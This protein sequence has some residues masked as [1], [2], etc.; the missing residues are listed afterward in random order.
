MRRYARIATSMSLVATVLVV[1]EIAVR[2]FGDI[3][4]ADYRTAGIWRRDED[5]GW[6][7][8][9]DLDVVVATGRGHVRVRTDGQGHRIDPDESR[10]HDGAFRVAVIGDSFVEALQ[11]EHRDALT[12]QLRRDL[13]H[14][15]RQPVV[16][17][18]AGVSGWGPVQ[19]GREARRLISRGRYDVVVVALLMEN[20]V[21]AS[22]E[23]PPLTEVVLNDR[24]YWPAE[25]SPRSVASAVLQPVSD[26]F[27][28]R[29]HLFHLLR[30][31]VHPW[32]ARL[33]LSTVSISPAYLR[34][35]EASRRWS[36]TADLARD[37]DARVRQAG[38]RAIFLL[39]PSIAQIQPEVTRRSAAIQGIAG[40][41]LDL[42]QPNRLLRAALE[43][44]GLHVVDALP[45]I[46][47][48]ASAGERPYF[49]WID[50]H[51][52]ARGHRVVAGV[53]ADAIARR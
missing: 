6:R 8:K 47:E 21:V 25:W 14:R 35:E 41:A 45:A 31:S 10:A 1:A 18:S 50:A 39:L 5:F 30:V 43:A 38:G 22:V 23:L 27:W 36:V 9:E 24:S 44:R 2:S 15:M 7:L 49:S 3:D 46:R 19:Y 12:A 16:V 11:L 42:E 20:D 26:I 34:A 13:E 40:E 52:S 33:G 29:S 17:T 51:L 28:M 53:V 32:L 48:S 37:T 4:Y